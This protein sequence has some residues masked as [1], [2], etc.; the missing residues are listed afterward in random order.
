MWLVL[1]IQQIREIIKAIGKGSMSIYEVYEYI[2]YF[3]RVVDA[4]K[5][6]DDRKSSYH[7]NVQLIGDY[8]NSLISV[9]PEIYVSKM[10]RS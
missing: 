2:T 9:T 8:Y 3:S 5:I 4:Y 1:Y 10:A 6:Q 7:N